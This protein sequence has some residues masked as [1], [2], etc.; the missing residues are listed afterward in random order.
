MARLRS[1][2]PVLVE[3]E[4]SILEAVEKMNVEKV[5]CVL[6]TVEGKLSG[7]LTERD[8]LFKVL[9][10]TSDLS[11]IAV[12]QVMTPDPETLREED[13]LAYAVNKMSVG[14]FR[15]IPVLRKGE[16]VGILSSRDLLSYLSKAFSV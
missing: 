1:R 6:V 10:K 15:H 8:I 14:G 13:T 5:G 4:S 2:S 12:R 7:I 9:E 3:E 16:P 11:R